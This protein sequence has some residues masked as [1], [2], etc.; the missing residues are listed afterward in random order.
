MIE[1]MLVEKHNT[2]EHQL[3]ELRLP[4]SSFIRFSFRNLAKN[5]KETYFDL[6]NNEFCLRP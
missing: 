3:F 4:E 1:E 5:E 6:Q 2:V